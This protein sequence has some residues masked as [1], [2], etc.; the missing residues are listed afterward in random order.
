MRIILTHEQADFD[1]LASMLGAYL[2]DKT[3]VPV[4]P[5]KMNRNVRAFVTLYGAELPFIDPHDLPNEPVESICLVDTQSMA[6][7]RGVGPDTR[8]HIVDHHPIRADL[9]SAWTISS[10][11]VGAT[12]TIF[13]EDL[14]ERNGELST[15]EATTLL[16][17]IYE[18]TGSLTYT[19]TSARDLHAASYLLEQEANLRIAGD[20]LNHPLSADQQKLYNNLREHLES[21]QIHGH[22]VVV[23]CGNAYG[24]D[25][26]LSTVAHKLRD[27]VDPDALFML[28]TT[29]AGVQMIGRSTSDQ[30]DVAEITSRF[31][32]GGHSRA[33]ASLIK[34]R[35]L[36]EVHDELIDLLP[37]FV[38]PAITVAEIMSHNPQVLETDTPVQVAAERMQ[39][40]GYEGYPVVRNGRVV[41]LLTRRAVDR[42]I[43]H[44][45]NLTAGSLMD[46]GEV[47][48]HP[49]DSID[50]LQHLMTDTGWGQIP[51]TDEANSEIIGIVTRTDLLKIL[52]AQATRRGY[53]N[54]A[55]KLEAAM[56]KARLALLKVVAEFGA[57]QKAALYIVG[58]FVRDLILEQT[59]QDFD[60]VVEGDAIA[61]ARQ[62]QERYGGRL[63]THARFGT[64]KWLITN[65][66]PAVAKS[67]GEPENAADLPEFLDLIS[68]RTEFYTHPTALPTVERGSIKLDLHRRDFTI[69]TLALRLD[70]NH[71]GEL[72]DYWGGVNDLKEGLVRVL[73]SLS[74]VDDPT[75]MLRAVR[76]E[77]RFDFKIEKR[78]LELLFEARSLLAQVSGDR[79]RHELDHIMDEDQ[80]VSMLERLSE[81]GLLQ[82]IHPALVWDEE[83]RQNLQMMSYRDSKPLLGLKLDLTRG[84]N[85]RRLAYILWIIHQP[86]E[87]VQAILR[88]LRYPATQIGVV[89]SACRL[90][91]DLP[92]LGNAKLSMIANR[93]EEVHPLAIYANFLAARDEHI[94]TNFQA[95]LNRV[96][97][98]VPTVTGYDLKDRGLAPGPAY[99]RI[100]GAIRDGWLDGKIENVDQE[101]AY[102]EELIRNEP[103]LHPASE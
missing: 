4:L 89:L 86:V 70:G 15:I 59:G 19:R 102:L 44:K 53:V 78:T 52:T 96:N 18:D 12:T 25:E 66:R 98:I 45:L 1:A 39:R 31:G 26:E 49:D 33:A 21:Y 94:C 76:F 103:S 55:D 56:P 37:E 43:A 84:S 69:N 24:M 54:Y 62:L 30:I 23:V 10:E 57:Q 6:T 41:G 91:K 20:F 68:A 14:Q 79:I 65:V 16:L 8:V 61:L 85:L 87:K 74:F 90:W 11:D 63:T 92:W 3:A 29:R 80:R 64:G 73:H 28:I 13:V 9:P 42:A 48:I 95:Y 88:R 58:G 36:D 97:I 38:R 100:L 5:R 46:E 22:C 71:Y 99:K 67:I 7:V 34:G 50:H 32:G 77:R 17:G 93:L 81:L 101:K 35:E 75:R 60:L 27:L 47:V 82:E 83:S 72:Y 51:V 2:L 40:F